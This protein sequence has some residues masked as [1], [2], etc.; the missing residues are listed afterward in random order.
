VKWKWSAATASTNVEMCGVQ[1]GFD[2][3]RKMLTTAC[4][5]SGL[6]ELKFADSVWPL[7]GSTPALGGVG[8]N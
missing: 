6:L 8:Y 5:R 4:I 1:L 3:Q 7:P 2:F